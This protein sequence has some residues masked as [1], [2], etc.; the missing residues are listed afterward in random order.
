M[1]E[2]K[3]VWQGKPV[4]G[5]P[6]T[7]PLFNGQIP[8]SLSLHLHGWIHLGEL[9]FDLLS[10]LVAHYAAGCC[11]Q[12]RALSAL[13]WCHCLAMLDSQPC[14]SGHNLALP[15]RGVKDN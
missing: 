13:V 10:R 15:K 14:D 11:S 5:Q 2:N 1:F 6:A 7:A 9:R 4:V 8:L 3:V 12:H